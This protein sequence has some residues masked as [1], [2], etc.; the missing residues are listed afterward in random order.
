MLSRYRSNITSPSIYIFKKQ[1]RDIEVT[2]KRSGKTLEGYDDSDILRIAGTI[3]GDTIRYWLQPTALSSFY[4][5][6]G[7]W[8]M[9]PDGRQLRGYWM[10]SRGDGPGQWDLD[11][12]Q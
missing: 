9:S 1:Y 5:V 11:K 12:I 8:K 3:D 2:P 10:D 4:D 6:G 7:E